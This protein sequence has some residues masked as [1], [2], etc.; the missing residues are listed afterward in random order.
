VKLDLVTRKLLRSGIL[1][2]LLAVGSTL[3]FGEF[4]AAVQ[5]E[6]GP[7]FT[8]IEENDLVVKTDRH[9]TQGIRLSYLHSDGFLPFGMSNVYEAL[10]QIGFQSEFGKFGYAVGQ[11][12]YT[13]ADTSLEDPPPDDRPYGGW[14]YLGLILQRRGLSFGDRPT[15]E[16]LE[17]DLGVVGPWALGKEAQTWVHELRGFDIPQGWSHQL[18]N[19]PGLRL[20][21][22]RTVRWRG[23]TLDSFGGEVLPHAGFSLGNVETSFR[24]GGTVR[25]GLHLPD[26]YGLQTIDSLAASG[27]G[28]TREGGPA[29]R[30]SLYAFAGAEGRVVAH[31]VFLD[32]NLFEPGPSVEKEI[33]VG[34][35][36]AGFAASYRAVEV[37][38]TQVWRTPEFHG[39][40]QEDSFGAVFLRLRF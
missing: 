6:Q 24:V 5:D 11:N 40:T 4:A 17:L 25:A 23:F 3:L 33:L 14:L 18:E 32:G 7:V 15:Q 2:R 13:P 29:S 26:D 16:D 10:P 30:W 22:Q 36:K 12:I 1:V 31:N 38:Y 9:Y 37:G 8:L 39:Q 28:R 34:D 27:S 35:F 20:R 19:E 21:Y